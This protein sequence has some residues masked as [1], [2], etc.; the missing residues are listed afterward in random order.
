M[1]EVRNKLNRQENMKRW[2]SLIERW[3]KSGKAKKIFCEEE[4]LHESTF[5]YW[6]SRFKQLIQPKMK[7]NLSEAVNDEPIYFSEIEIKSDVPVTSSLI[8]EHHHGFSIRVERH[9][10][11]EL[12]RQVLA[13]FSEKR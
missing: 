2:R 5:E 3:K 7:D 8:V 12:L 10:D 9:F 1:G 13:C 4:T 11:S 6:I